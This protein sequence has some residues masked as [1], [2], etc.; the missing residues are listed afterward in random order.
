MAAVDGPRPLLLDACWEEAEDGRRRGDV[1]CPRF[2][3]SVPLVVCEYGDVG[4]GSA[5]ALRCLVRSVPFGR[6][7]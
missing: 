7:A 3:P 2:L 6:Q 1:S 5:L 4:K